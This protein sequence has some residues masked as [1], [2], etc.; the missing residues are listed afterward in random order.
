MKSLS[1]HNIFDE[2]K[3]IGCLAGGMIAGNVVL[4][5]DKKDSML[6]PAAMAGG[7]LIGAAF[8]DN[9]YLKN[10]AL[11]ASVLGII[12]LLNKVSAVETTEA[13]NG[14][15][16]FKLPEGIRTA[17]QKYIPQLGEAENIDFSRLS[18]DIQFPEM[19]NLSDPGTAIPTDPVSG[20]LGQ[21]SDEDVMKLVA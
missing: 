7:G 14:L 3:V 12:K 15:L 21:L 5:M 10:L 9:K 20:F 4:K 11:G 6:F 8:F 19:R 13:T 17:L 2:S 16:G 18:D 1:L